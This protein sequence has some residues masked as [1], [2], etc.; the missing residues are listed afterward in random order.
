MSDSLSKVVYALQHDSTWQ[1]S[2]DLP[3]LASALDE[4]DSRLTALEKK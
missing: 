2:S 4:I 3:L 1:L